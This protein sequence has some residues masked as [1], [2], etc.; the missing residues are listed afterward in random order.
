MAARAVNAG[1]VLYPGR[2]FSGAWPAPTSHCHAWRVVDANA[3]WSGNGKDHPHRHE[4]AT[5]VTSRVHGQSVRSGHAFSGSLHA[6][7]VPAVL[8]LSPDDRSL[9]DSVQKSKSLVANRV[10]FLRSRRA[11]GALARAPVVGVVGAVRRCR[12]GGRSSRDDS[13]LVAHSLHSG[14]PG[15]RHPFGAGLNP[16]GQAQRVA[17]SFGPALRWLKCA[18][19]RRWIAQLG[20]FARV[21]D[22][23]VSRPVRSVA[24]GG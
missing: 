5:A 21:V 24:R 7:P 23:V 6:R 8:L 1:E 14:C 22:G 17:L 2:S 13:R 15:A 9:T 20:S 4:I 18:A 16:E 11:F 3:H 19:V 10:A 12:G